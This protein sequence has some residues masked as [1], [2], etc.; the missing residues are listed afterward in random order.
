M[1]FA[2]SLSPLNQGSATPRARRFTLAGFCLDC[3]IHSAW[4]RQPA[5]RQ[6]RRR[7]RQGAVMPARRLQTRPGQKNPVIKRRGQV[8]DGRLRAPKTPHRPD[9]SNPPVPSCDAVPI[10]C[11]CSPF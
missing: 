8:R 6:A 2:G 11:S 7:G 1:R 4:G 9:T 3:L 10:S 5:E